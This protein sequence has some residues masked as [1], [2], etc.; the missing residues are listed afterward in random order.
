MKPALPDLNSVAFEFA[1]GE[2]VTLLGGP[3]VEITYATTAP[4]TELNV[5]LWDV[6]PD[7]TQALVTRGTYRSL[8]GPGTDLVAR[9]QIAPTG[10]RFAAGHTIKLEVTAN[11]APYRQPSNIPALL[12]PRARS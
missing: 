12:F 11:D 3:V 9:F 7:G 1:V 10:Y 2:A 5:R 4:D 8:D 6:T